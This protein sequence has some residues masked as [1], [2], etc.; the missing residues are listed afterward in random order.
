MRKKAIS[1]NKLPKKAVISLTGDFWHWRFK[2]KKRAPQKHPI[3]N[4]LKE[5]LYKTKAS[6]S[7]QVPHFYYREGHEKRLHDDSANDDSAIDKMAARFWHADDS[8]TFL[9][10][11]KGQIFFLPLTGF[12]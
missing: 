12:T 5:S 1:R 8:A 10:E 9:F 3:E 6:Q 2:S 4:F 7:E 11:K